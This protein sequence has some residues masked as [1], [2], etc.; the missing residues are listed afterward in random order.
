MNFCTWLRE[1]IVFNHCT[2]KCSNFL[3]SCVG[4]SD[5][6]Q[7]KF[8]EIRTNLSK[9]SQNGKG[10]APHGEHGYNFIG[11]FESYFSLL[12]N[13]VC[14]KAKRRYLFKKHEM[15]F[16]GAVKLLSGVPKIIS[17]SQPLN[18]IIT[19][20]W[21]YGTKGEF[22]LIWLQDC[23]QESTSY[24][25]PAMI[26]KN[27]IMNEFDVEQYPTSCSIENEELVINWNGTQSSMKRF[28]DTPNDLL[29]SVCMDGIAVIKDRVPP[30]RAK[31]PVHDVEERIRF[32]WERICSLEHPS[33]HINRIDFA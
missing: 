31:N 10:R 20:Q 7:N 17:V 21:K 3:M 13:R 23:S 26:A 2:L 19:V 15:V 18:R 1:E 33:K 14:R 29:E 12:I 32:Y 22:L 8:M 27:L 28:T 24:F 25:G 4:A 9:N 30:R 11:I 6:L 5:R 16:G